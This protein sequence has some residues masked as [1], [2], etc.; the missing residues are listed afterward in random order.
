MTEASLTALDP[1]LVSGLNCAAARLRYVRAVVASLSSKQVLPVLPAECA[2]GPLAARARTDF[3][4]VLGHP[5]P[6]RARRARGQGREQS[7]PG[8]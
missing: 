3:V 1:T 4:S 8:S 6:S 7:E 5:E 2:L